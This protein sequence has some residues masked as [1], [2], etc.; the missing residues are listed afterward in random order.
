M[1]HFLKL[2]VVENNSPSII[3]VSSKTLNKKFDT[4]IICISDFTFFKNRTN[5]PTQKLTKQSNNITTK[6]STY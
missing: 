5:F 2:T 6:Q 4:H 1:K 3:N